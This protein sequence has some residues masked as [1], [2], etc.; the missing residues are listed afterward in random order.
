MKSA[1]R[2]NA[3]SAGER[4]QI[5]ELCLL[6]LVKKG[7]TKPGVDHR[8]VLVGDLNQA[9]A[10]HKVM[11]LSTWGNPKSSF[12][13]SPVLEHLKDTDFVD[14]KNGVYVV[15]PKGLRYMRQCS[16][17]LRMAAAKISCDVLDRLVEA[18][19]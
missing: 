15:T 18:V 1:L 10:N 11:D 14:K 8:L 5:L 9:L 4:L 6:H 13:F 17:R 7:A 12:P 3:Y 2:V 19:R 16:K